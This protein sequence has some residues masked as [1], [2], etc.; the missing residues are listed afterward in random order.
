MAS[1][2][3]AQLKAEAAAAMTAVFDSF[4]RDT[5][6]AFYKVAE[7]T[8][9]ALDP[10]YNADFMEGSL[11]AGATYETESQSFTC[12]IIYLD[13]QDFDTTLGGGEDLGVKGK[14]FY[15]RVKLQCKED[16]FLYLK[17]SERFEFLGELYHIEEAWRRI[18]ILDTFQF[19]Q[20][21][22]RR[23]S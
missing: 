22:L 16:A 7:R 9:V 21:I 10:N 20:I 11:L 4:S 1:L 13:R 2:I 5:P 15:N 19:Y 8:I 6:V 14:F 17:D 23:V 12:R 3:S 18:G